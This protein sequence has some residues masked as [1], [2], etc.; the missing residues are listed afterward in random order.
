MYLLYLT[1]SMKY[2]TE[3]TVVLELDTLGLYLTVYLNNSYMNQHTVAYLEL[4]SLKTPSTKQ[5]F[6]IKLKIN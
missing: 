5:N 6:Y 1:H 4:S 2:F 3:T